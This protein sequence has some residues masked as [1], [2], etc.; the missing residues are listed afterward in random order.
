LQG[1]IT[2]EADVILHHVIMPCLAAA[3]HITFPT[4]VAPTGPLNSAATFTATSHLSPRFGLTS[5]SQLGRMVYLAYMQD[6]NAADKVKIMFEIWKSRQNLKH[7]TATN[8]QKKTQLWQEISCLK[9]FAGVPNNLWK[10]VRRRRF[11]DWVISHKCST[12]YI[13]LDQLGRLEP[14]LILIT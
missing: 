1:G 12:G 10:A 2:F 14:G 4:T 13:S 3:Y 9:I 8:R 11:F 6:P 7:S 5:V